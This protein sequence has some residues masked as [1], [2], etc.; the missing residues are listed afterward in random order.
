M[1]KA[2]LLFMICIGAFSCIFDRADEDIYSQKEY[3]ISKA[4]NSSKRTGRLKVRLISPPDFDFD[5]LIL[6]ASRSFPDPVFDKVQCSMLPL[7]IFYYCYQNG[8]PSVRKN[9][10]LQGA[11]NSSVRELEFSAEQG[12][13][14]ASIGNGFMSKGLR[15]S[16]VENKKIFISF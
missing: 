11:L 10:G 9:I 3:N 6:N 16:P 2:F 13:Y 4:A 12:I 8:Y 7:P 14:Y 15:F 1:I 5:E